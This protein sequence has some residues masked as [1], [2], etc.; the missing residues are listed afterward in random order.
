[1][2]DPASTFVDAGVRIGQDTTLH[3]FTT[4]QGSTIIGEDCQI[5]PHSVVRDSQVG[6]GCAVVASWVEESTLEPGVRV[7]PMSHLR[8]GAY[9][10]AGVHVGN[11]A[12][13]KN[14]RLGEG[15]QQHH[16]SYIGD[17]SIGA[18]SNVG[19][20]TITCNY[21][22]ERKH[23]T[24]VGEDVFLGS[25]TL[26][27]APVTVADGAQTGAGAVVRQDVPPHA[28]VA[29]VPARLIRYREPRSARPVSD[30]DPASPAADDTSPSQMT[31]AAASG[32]ERPAEAQA[33]P[34]TA[35]AAPESEFPSRRAH[36][37]SN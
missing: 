36:R 11:F 24:E 9:L 21:D 6:D 28:V 15:V 27:V 4:I 37:R 3:P 29:G 8:P 5:G 33:P 34:P 19:A 17:A 16:F 14:A 22:G 12:E 7:G 25:D 26:L 13:V 30:A 20:G 2:V 10:A 35:A 31:A 32:E 18:R 23:H 1:V